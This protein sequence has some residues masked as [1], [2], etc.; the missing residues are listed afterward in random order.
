[1]SKRWT[2]VFRLALL[3]VVLVSPPGEA[4]NNPAPG[5]EKQLVVV[6][7]VVKGETATLTRD[8]F[9][10]LD[11]GQPQ[12]IVTFDAVGGQTNIKGAVSLPAQAAANR[13]DWRG[14]VPSSATVVLIDRINTPT[15]AQV[16]VNQ[17][18]RELLERFDANLGIAVYELRSDGLRIVHD[19]TD[20]P[21]QLPERLARLEPEHSLALESSARAGGF[22]SDLDTVGLDPQLEE[23]RTGTTGFSR[24]SADYFMNERLLRTSAALETV[25][26]H[27]QGLRGRRNL[28]WLAGRFPFSFDVWARTDLSEVVEEAT[29][30]Q[31]DDVAALIREANTAIYPV[32][33]RG[34]GGEGAEVAGIAR[35]IA[36]ST[37]GR[38]FRTNAI[39]E[40]VQAALSDSRMIYRL[41]FYPSQPSKDRSRRSLQ[42]E[43]RQPGAELLY[44]THYTSIGGPDQP[45]RRVGVVELL[46]S[47]L[48]ATRIG[49]T[50]MA[51]PIEGRSG[52]F[53]LVMLVDMADLRLIERDGRWV[54]ALNVGLV[55]RAEDDG[56][57]YV[58]PAS[59]SPISLT[60]EQYRTLQKTGLVL[61][62]FL[63]TEG[64]P[65][66]VRVVIEEQATG[67]AGSVW[68]SVGSKK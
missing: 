8:D 41:A 43:V 23:I 3:A 67:A 60:R 57:A 46:S 26:R 54:G 63:N 19:F 39:S 7:I 24:R 52:S 68:V 37:G 5:A 47:P 44:R 6:D 11:N 61:Q 9:R 55:F 4:Q 35:E 29:M 33:V 51:A 17:H 58:I 27:I 30:R 62:R 40:A 12:Q 50:A 38:S 2:N 21:R 56:T 13:R 20:N 16:Y 42:V 32:D 22:E 45:G 64:R 25:V 28:V 10:I 53:E 65:G 1:M 66:A 34:P 18:V 15:E 31:V 48:D 36:R 14:A 49:I 59:E